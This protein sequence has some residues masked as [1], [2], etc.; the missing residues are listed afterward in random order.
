MASCSGDST[1]CIK[2]VKAA[3]KPSLFCITE[4]QSLQFQVSC[5]IP[6]L[7]NEQHRRASCLHTNVNVPCRLVWDLQNVERNLDFWMERL[8]QGKHLRTMLFGQGPVSFYKDARE[9]VLKHQRSDT[10]SDRIE[11]RVRHSILFLNLSSSIT[12]YSRKAC[13]TA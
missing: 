5:T 2:Q 3:S 13:R 7:L 9:A 6:R 4:H 8:R 1:N 11:R 12:L 10:A